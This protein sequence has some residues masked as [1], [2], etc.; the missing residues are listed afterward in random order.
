MKVKEQ[1]KKKTKRWMRFRH[2]LITTVG[3]PIMRVYCRLRYGIRIEPFKEQGDRPYLVL[4]N[5]QTGFDQFFVATVMHGPVYYVATE[6]IFSLGWVSD[7]LRYLIAPIPIRKQTTDIQAVMTCIRVAR[8]GGTIAIAPEG[9]RTYSGRS[10]YMNPAIASLAKKMGL[11]IALLR[12]EGGYGV[13]PRWSDVVRKGK[14]RAY[15]SQVIEPEDYKDK[16][17]DA[18]LAMIREGLEVNEAQVSG[19]FR[20]KRLAEYMER[21]IYVCPHCGL[22]E[23]ESNG[24]LVRCKSCGLEARYLPT[25]EF[26]GT[27]GDFP[28]RFVLDWYDYQCRFVNGLDLSAYTETPLFRDTARLSEVI[29][30]KHKKLLREECRITLY[31][32]RAVIDE[33]TAEEL[34]FPFAETQA[35]TVLGKN[36]LNIYHGKQV[37][38]LKGSKRFNALKYVNLFHRFKNIASGDGNNDFLGI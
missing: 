37:Y 36:K 12:I 4:Y 35:F 18:L 7:L 33:G 1:E 21:L 15:V 32:D 20:H 2:K 34:V 24:D 25:K 9:N 11:P 30:Y 10:V 5:H 38:Q 13:Q 28:F 3:R 22:A 23:F 27:K 19:T 29:V 17:A 6:D 16:T 8:E 14:M 31:G 26:E